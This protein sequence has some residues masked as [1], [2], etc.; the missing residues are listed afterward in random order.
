MSGTSEESM[1]KYKISRSLAKA[2]TFI[3]WGVVVLSVYGL[4]HLGLTMMSL[5]LIVG[6]FVSGFLLVIAGQFTRAT[7]DT[8]D[9]TSQILALM[10]SKDDSA[11]Q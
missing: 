2:V 7:I 11:V 5:Y 1:S 9:N 10:K 8:A 6:S 4:L 3:G